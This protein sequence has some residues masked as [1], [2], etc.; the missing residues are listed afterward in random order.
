MP[1]NRHARFRAVGR[2]WLGVLERSGLQ[3]TPACPGGGRA[4]ND[5]GAHSSAAECAECG[6]TREHHGPI[7]FVPKP[8]DDY[9]NPEEWEAT[10]HG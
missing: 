8:T 2:L 10:D 9:S 7:P 6:E 1:P 3:R 5:A 4:V